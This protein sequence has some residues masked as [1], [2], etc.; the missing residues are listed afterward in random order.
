[1]TSPP[2]PK[3]RQ[4][5]PGDQ[6]NAVISL[7]ALR[8]QEYTG[9]SPENRASFEKNYSRLKAALAEGQD[10]PDPNEELR[11]FMGERIVPIQE[12]EPH[13]KKEI[14]EAIRRKYASVME[15]RAAYFEEI[16]Q[17]LT[18]DLARRMMV[19]GRLLDMGCHSCWAA[20]TPRT[21]NGAAKGRLTIHECESAQ[22]SDPGKM[23]VFSVLR[24]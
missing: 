1:M 12:P 3:F 8:V 4:S 7:Q 15:E 23:R 18:A 22:I 17:K 14:N 19:Q 5:N 13:P 16:R 2:Q 24:R 21:A 20:V 10:G 9:K 11:Q 6:T